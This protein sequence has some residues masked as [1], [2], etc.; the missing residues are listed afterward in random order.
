VTD[1]LSELVWAEHEGFLLRRVFRDRERAAWGSAEW[2][3]LRVL[4]EAAWD[5]QP[6]GLYVYA[7]QAASREV[8]Y[9]HNLRRVKA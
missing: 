9:V 2:R 7:V 6:S 8:D 4:T 3:L 1:A 5:Q